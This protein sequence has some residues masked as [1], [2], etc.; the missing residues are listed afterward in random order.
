MALMLSGLGADGRLGTQIDR[1]TG[2]PLVAGKFVAADAG[3]QG[4][5]DGFISVR[6][7]VYLSDES[8]T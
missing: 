1:C 6:G 3:T 4:Q 8:W 2:I 7:V 5:H